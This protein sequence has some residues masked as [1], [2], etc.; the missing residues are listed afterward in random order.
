MATCTECSAELTGEFCFQCGAPAA[1]A[2]LRRGINPVLK[3]VLI[4]FGSLVGVILLAAVLVPLFISF[5]GSNPPP[6]NPE[7]ERENV[8]T[9]IQ[10]LMVDNNFVEVTP[11]TSGASGEKIT[12]TSTQ[13]HP[14]IDLQ[15]YWNPSTTQFCYRWNTNG[16]I[17]FQYDYDDA[18]SCTSFQLYP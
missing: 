12:S 16:R 11:S 17:T 13:F 5:G 4:S 7:A 15:A 9:A 3:W 8:Q 2:P 18:G 10:S 1:G 14:T 6:K